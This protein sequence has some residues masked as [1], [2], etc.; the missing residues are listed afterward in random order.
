MV[1]TSGEVVVQGPVVAQTVDV[2]ELADGLG[3]K[4]HHALLGAGR[5]VGHRLKRCHGRGR[6]AEHGRGCNEV[7]RETHPGGCRRNAPIEG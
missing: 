2:G 6:E 4:L 3:N 7:V 5:I 1:Y